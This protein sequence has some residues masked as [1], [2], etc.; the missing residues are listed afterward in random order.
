[1]TFVS[2]D[3]VPVA[4]MPGWLEAYAGIS[5]VTVTADTLRLDGRI[6]AGVRPAIGEMLPAHHLTG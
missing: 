1:M 2:P 6:V 4:T 3:F 5:A